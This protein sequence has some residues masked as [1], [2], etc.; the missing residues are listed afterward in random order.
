[1]RGAPYNVNSNKTYKSEKGLLYPVNV[2]RN[3]ARD[4]AQTHFVFANDIELYPSRDFT[5]NFFKMISENPQYLLNKDPK[6]FVFPIFE[7]K[8]DEEVPEDKI[9]L[10]ELFFSQRAIFFHKKVCSSCHLIPKSNEWI[11]DIPKEGL[12]I[13]TKTKRKGNYANWEPLYI[14]T[15]TDP[16]YDERLTWE[17]ASDKMTQV[18]FFLYEK[19]Q[20]SI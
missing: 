19:L 6:V 13:F 14:G 20:I 11:N 17:G 8:A 12:S 7:V 5:E 3:I 18:C 4:N 10:Q 2:G 9:H 16:P 15:K 1:M